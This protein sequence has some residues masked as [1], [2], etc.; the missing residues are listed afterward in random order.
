M[1]K[2]PTKETD[3]NNLKQDWNV[4]VYWAAD[5]I[6]KATRQKTVPVEKVVDEL[7][8]LLEKQ[9]TRHK[10]RYEIQIRPKRTYLYRYVAKKDAL[11]L[12][13]PTGVVNMSMF[14]DDHNLKDLLEI[15]ES[16]IH[17]KGVFAKK[18]LKVHR[19]IWASYK[20]VV[21][22]LWE[23]HEW[24]READ[25]YN[26]TVPDT[27]DVLVYCPLNHKAQFETNW[28]NPYSFYINLHKLPDY[29]ANVQYYVP[30]R[31]PYLVLIQVTRPIRAGQELVLDSYG[32]TYSI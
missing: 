18:D 6:Q 24:S 26:M 4:L 1:L 3:A 15:K 27:N 14:V 31:A 29:R 7:Y 12:W 11:V 25:V 19:I 23:T 16:P 8:E 32:D 2:W 13:C 28:P 30:T 21:R 17:G 9:E 22:Y 5:Q 20:G 10:I